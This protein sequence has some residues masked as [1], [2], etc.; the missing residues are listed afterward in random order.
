MA[1]TRNRIT[2]QHFAGDSATAQAPLRFAAASLKPNTPIQ[3]GMDDLV[4]LIHTVA[5]GWDRPDLPAVLANIRQTA[6]YQY[7][8]NY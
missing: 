3:N 1:P 7:Y 8:R 6:Q 4:G 2:E 5:P